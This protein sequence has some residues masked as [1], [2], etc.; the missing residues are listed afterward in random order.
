MC[1]SVNMRH[2]ENSFSNNKESILLYGDQKMRT[3]PKRGEI[4]KIDI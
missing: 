2:A 3:N 1:G 4:N